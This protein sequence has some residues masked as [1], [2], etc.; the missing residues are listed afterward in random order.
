MTSLYTGEIPFEDVLKP[1]QLD[2]NRAAM[3]A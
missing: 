3:A 1:L 2:S